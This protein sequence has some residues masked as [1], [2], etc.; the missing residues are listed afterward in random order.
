MTNKGG[1]P[2]VITPEVLLKLEEAFSIGAT[3]LEACG[4]AGISKSSLYKYQ[5]ENPEF[6]ERKEY[7]KNMLK[8]QARYNVSEKL[9]DGDADIS[10]WYLE[11]KGKEEFST[12]HENTGADGEPLATVINIVNPDDG[13]QTE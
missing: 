2:T 12:R 1:R 4:R 8:Y 13:V 5:E 6:T 10:K 7:L 11:R 9:N 3:D